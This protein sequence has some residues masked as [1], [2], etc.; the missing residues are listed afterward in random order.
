M[1]A[2]LLLY[3]PDIRQAERELQAAGLD[4]QVARKNFYPKLII[5][6]GVGYQAFNARYLLVTPEA[7]L[8][9]LAGESSA[10]ANHGRSFT[11]STRFVNPMRRFSCRGC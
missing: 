8:Y 4:V 5:N 10:S 9:N 7:L 11:T 2:Q 1:P 6:G 3:R